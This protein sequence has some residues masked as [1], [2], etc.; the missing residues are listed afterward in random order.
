MVSC[1]R[2]VLTHQPVQAALYPTRCTQT[3]R[4]GD[5]AVGRKC[6]VRHGNTGDTGEYPENEVAKMALTLAV[7][8][9]RGGGFT[10]EPHH[11]VAPPGVT[12]GPPR[13]GRG[14]L[15]PRSGAPRHSD[16]GLPLGAS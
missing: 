7:K 8:A 15:R 9:A 6:N 5:A 11:R 16:A 1:S 10:P 14:D 12:R 2:I 3:T 4:P 13:P